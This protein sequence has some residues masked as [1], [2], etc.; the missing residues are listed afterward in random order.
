M[1]VLVKREMERA[2]ADRALASGIVLTGGGAVL[3]QMVGLAERVFRTPVRLGTPL[4]LNGLVD[5]VASPM[6]STSVGLVLHGLRQ[7]GG[8]RARH[9]AGVLGQLRVMRERMSGWLKEFF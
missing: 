6:Y 8:S 5:A 1:L 3:D 4:H 2:L 7:H 9:T